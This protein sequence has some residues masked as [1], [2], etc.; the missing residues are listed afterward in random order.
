MNLK[1]SNYIFNKLKGYLMKKESSFIEEYFNNSEDKFIVQIGAN[2]GVQNDPLRKYFTK[3]DNY[4]AILIEPIPYYVS[5]LKNLYEGRQDI[6]IL[7]NA[8]SEFGETNTLYYINPKIADEMNGDGPYNDWAHG[9]GSFS[10]DIVK[11][12]IDKNSFRGSNY[13]RGIEKYHNSIDSIELKSIKTSDLIPNHKNILLVIDVQG[14][15]INVLNGI[16]FKNNPPKY[17]IAEDDINKENKLLNFMKSKSYSWIAGNTNK[18]FKL[19]R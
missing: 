7:Q 17:I 15:E 16:D 18:V 19:K 2:D 11:Y 10:K 4:K 8:C 1:K 5:K 12:W 13:I 3:Q 6:K 9:Q 14:F